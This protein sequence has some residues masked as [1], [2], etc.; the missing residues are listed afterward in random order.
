MSAVQLQMPG[1]VRLAGVALS[2]LSFGCSENPPRGTGSAPARSGTSSAPPLVP[3]PGCGSE[4]EDTRHREVEVVDATL[5]LSLSK[6]G[7]ESSVGAMGIAAWAITPTTVT[8]SCQTVGTAEPRSGFYRG[9][10][11]QQTYCQ[12]TIGGRKAAADEELAAAL[13]PIDSPR[14]ALGLVALRYVVAYGPELASPRPEKKVRMPKELA[15]GSVDAF[16][17]D[18][19]DGGFI[20]RVPRESSCPRSVIRRAYRVATDGSV[21]AAKERPVLLDVGDGLCSD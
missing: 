9:G 20:V 18:R 2:L 4:R 17:V 19:F 14:K 1:P 16:D 3:D 10:G 12:Y 11:F 8:S 6:F 21:C 13:A 15:A 7:P 5:K